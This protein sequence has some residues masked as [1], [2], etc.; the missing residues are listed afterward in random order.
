MVK[1][2]NNFINIFIKNF[3]CSLG[4]NII[5]V[6]IRAIYVFILPKFITVEDFGYWQLYFLYTAFMPFCHLGLVEGIYLR[7][8]GIRYEELDK[9]EI[10]SQLITIFF[11]SVICISILLLFTSNF[12]NDE[13]KRYIFYILCITVL[14]SLPRM[15]FSGVLQMT[16]LIKQDSCALLSE[17]LVS[18]IGVVIIILLHCSN[19][20]LFILSDCIGRIFSLYL[21]CYFMSDIIKHIKIT[22]I[23][24][25]NSFKN[26]KIGIYLLFSNMV[27]ML[28]LANFSF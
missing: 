6:F 9:R 22:D 25:V 27:G 7:K 3:S 16:G 1:M 28:A 12:I 20:K 18:F 11:M 26:I 2:K 4:A 15:L 10:R 23:D 5:L 13:N 8:G 24:F 19:F 21:S 17:I 14:I